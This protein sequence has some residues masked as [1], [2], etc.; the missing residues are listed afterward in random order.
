M[1]SGGGEGDGGEGGGMGRSE[2]RSTDLESVGK[3]LIHLQLRSLPLSQNKLLE[4]QFLISAL[5]GP[6]AGTSMVIF[7]VIQLSKPGVV[8][9]IDLIS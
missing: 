1:E 2:E 6:T 5:N 4:L 8:H 9:L 7:K 3:E